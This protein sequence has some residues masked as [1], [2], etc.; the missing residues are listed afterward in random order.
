M[1]QICLSAPSMPCRFH[2]KISVFVTLLMSYSPTLSAVESKDGKV[3]FADQ[4]ERNESQEEQEE[5]TNGWG[6]NSNKRANGNKQVD[7][8]DGTMHIYFH[9]SAD[10]AVSVTHPAE[11]TD[12]VVKLRFMLPS[13]K[14]SLGLN[15]ADLNYKKVH[16]GHLCV[17]R[18]SA[19]EIRL[20]DLKTGNMD[21]KIREQR[22][23]KKIDAATQKMLAAK[24]KNI[25]YQ[26]EPEKWYALEVRIEGEKMTAKIDNKEVGHF[27]SEGIAHPTKRTLRLSVPN[28]VYIDD[29][30]I[31][32]FK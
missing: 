26:L 4:F 1:R 14:D 2:T 10:H 24:T 3:I 23:A 15:F 21:L 22:L 9:E 6:S 13:K 8:V 20:Q 12:G 11:F 29:I 17:A 27:S 19:K 30:Q 16:A 28:E 18:F 7:L 32:R 5:L 31:V 25:Q